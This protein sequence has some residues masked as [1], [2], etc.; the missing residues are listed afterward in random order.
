[1]RHQKGRWQRD[2]REFSS[3]FEAA[4]Y[5][6]LLVDRSNPLGPVDTNVRVIAA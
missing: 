4:I 6:M 3:Y 2:S 1:M 5:A